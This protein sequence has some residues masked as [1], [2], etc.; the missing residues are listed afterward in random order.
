M[1]FCRNFALEKEDRSFNIALNIFSDD[2]KVKLQLKDKNNVSQSNYITRTIFRMK[3]YYDYQQNRLNE[4]AL[5]L[6]YYY[7]KDNQ[8]ISQLLE[9]LEAYFVEVLNFSNILVNF[10]QTP[11]S[12]RIK[13]LKK[14]Y[15][16]VEDFY[17]LLESKVFE[18]TIRKMKE[19]ILIY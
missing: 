18:N 15:E 6:Y 2:E 8:I 14:W 1:L 5:Y 7:K 9:V 11:N 17:K 13:I 12:E 16:T 19:E 3:K 10:S 4:V